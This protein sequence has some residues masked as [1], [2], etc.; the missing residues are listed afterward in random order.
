MIMDLHE[1]VKKLN[2]P[3]S[4]MGESNMD[5]KRFENLKTMIDLADQLIA[6]IQFASRYAGSHKHS[7][8]KIGKHAKEWINSLNPES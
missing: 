7:V 4:P 3:I 1:I 8:S 6:D 5:T 2:G